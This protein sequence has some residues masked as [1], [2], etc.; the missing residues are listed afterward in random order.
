MGVIGLGWMGRKHVEYARSLRGAKLVA[1]ADIDP[2]RVTEVT[3]LDPAV[4]GYGDYRDLLQEAGVDAVI[5]ATPPGDRVQMVRDCL[6]AGKHVL[7]EKPIARDPH[8]AELVVEMVG[9]GRCR[10]MT[11]FP[12]RFAV[13]NVQVK[14]LIDDGKIGDVLFFRNNRRWTKKADDAVRHGSWIRDRQR[15]GG[16]LIEASTHGWDLLRW[17]TGQEVATLYC[18]IVE[19]EGSEAI[20]TMTGT[21]TNGACFMLDIVGCLPQGSSADD[22]TEVIGSVGMAYIDEFRH[23]LEVNSEVGVEAS[24]HRRATG[25]V[26][27]ECM[28][29]SPVEGAVKREQQYF[30]D[31]LRTGKEP[32]PGAEDGLAALR[33]AWA[34][35]ESAETGR[36]VRLRQLL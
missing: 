11:G 35:C 25:L 1:V 31:C 10:F 29:H 36:P 24:P 19:V 9:Q 15:G 27:P 13:A 18:R 12:E 16:L 26:Y 20:V 30:V 17:M 7:C 4:R 8:D 34:A 14:R 21:L 22:R 6:D 33:L 3:A 5:V 32:Q 28:W 23:L 2:G